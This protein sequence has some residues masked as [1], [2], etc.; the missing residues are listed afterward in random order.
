[1]SAL[2]RHVGIIMDGNGRWAQVRG[3]PR[4]EGHRVGAESVRD[5]T[6]AARELGIEAL[7]L[8]A[9]S[10]QNW[11]RPADEVRGL[12]EL[13]RDYLHDE[14]AEIMDNQIR[15]HA[16]GDLDRLPAMVREPL[17]AL[18]RDSAHHRG[19][20]LT[21]ALSY[22][23]RESLA[24]AAAALARDVAAG[25]VDARAI[26]ADRLGSYLPTAQLPQLDLLVRTSGEQRISNFMLWELAY[27]E[28]V[29]IDV[30]WPDFRRAE[31]GRCLAQ[32]ANRERRFGLTGAQ[33]VDDASDVE[34]TGA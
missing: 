15:L 17:E 31:L 25:T 9:F 7:T 19:M 6:R 5:I 22:G 33:L 13:L 27:A 20:T 28:L 2:P 32:Y 8:Y 14:R 26:D 10:A 16:I 3:L 1:M 18:R 4:L 24:A 21:L 34:P 30:M 29:F 11:A 12:M 23:G